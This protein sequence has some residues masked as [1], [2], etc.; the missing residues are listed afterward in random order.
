L[1]PSA[2]RRSAHDSHSAAPRRAQQCASSS[3]AP[4]AESCSA[5]ARLCSTV[6]RKPSIRKIPARSGGAVWLRRERRTNTAT[7]SANPTALPAHSS[8]TTQAVCNDLQA[9]GAG[10]KR[11]APV[12]S[13]YSHRLPAP[14]AC[15]RHTGQRREPASLRP[16]ARQSKMQARWNPWE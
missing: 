13:S 2:H 16:A 5:R 7:G 11:G 9:P 4:V 6:A 14:G 1:L 12:L 10:A 3:A 8:A 15:S